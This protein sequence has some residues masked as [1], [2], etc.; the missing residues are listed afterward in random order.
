LWLGGGALAK[1]VVFVASWGNAKALRQFTLKLKVAPC[2][3][4]RKL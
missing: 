1:S 2:L 4:P 3:M